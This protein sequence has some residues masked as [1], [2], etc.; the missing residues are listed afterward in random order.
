MGLLLK[1]AKEI[2]DHWHKVASDLGEI[3]PGAPQTYRA[4]F[5]ET[6]G[7]VATLRCQQ[8]QNE[9]ADS[10]HG[11]RP[12]VPLIDA[13]PNESPVYWINWYEE[14]APQRTAASRFLRF[15]T[16]AITVFYG[17]S[18]AP[19]HQLLR[20]EWAGVEAVKDGIDVFQ[21]KGAAHPHWH[22]DA[23]RSYI[24]DF[25]RHL[26]DLSRD[27]ELRRNLAID[28]IREFGDED[29]EQ[30]VSQLLV[31]K[32]LSLPPER[33][34]IWTAAHL[35]LSARWSEQSWPGVEGPHSSHACGPTD[36]PNI[37]NWLTSCVRY[38]QAENNKAEIG[39]L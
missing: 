37:R 18:D 32:P 25:R 22:I 33:E 16:S 17:V 12:L 28:R 3:L 15:H 24:T 4:L 29:A 9:I 20:A 19:K 38:I 39:L 36:L 35:A 31:S 30:D 2:K 11:A 21:G 5:E 7:T 23:V 27:I 26:E 13:V 34:L 1:R 8:F 6:A 14:W 10:A